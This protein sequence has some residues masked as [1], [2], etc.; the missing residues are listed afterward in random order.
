VSILNDLK[1]LLLKN[2]NC[3]FK[4]QKFRYFHKIKTQNKQIFSN[5]RKFILIKLL[6]MKIKF[7]V[8]SCELQLYQCF[9]LGKDSSDKYLIGQKSERQLCKNSRTYQLNSYALHSFLNEIQ[10]CPN[11]H[12]CVA[13]NIKCS[14]SLFVIKLVPNKTEYIDKIW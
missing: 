13:R 10:C 8:L 12:Y 6:T 4:I 3:W 1:F 11:Y 14:D 9:L 2:L 7:Y 5:L